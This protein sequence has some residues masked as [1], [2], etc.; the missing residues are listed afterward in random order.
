MG[1]AIRIYPHVILYWLKIICS[2]RPIKEFILDFILLSVKCIWI[3]NRKFSLLA[4]LFAIM[5]L[6]TKVSV[7]LR[8]ED[9]SYFY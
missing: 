8:S 6:F 5:C 9:K 7:P 3:E 4:N 2:P 1:S